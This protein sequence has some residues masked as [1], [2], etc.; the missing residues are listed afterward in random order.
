VDTDLS[1]FI[2][3][4]QPGQNLLAIHGLNV[5]QGSS[6]FL[7]DAEI[8]VS[9]RHIIS[10]DPI[11]AVYTQPIPV[12]DLTTLKARAFSGSEWSALVEA[13]FTVGQPR[14][15]ITELNYHPSDPT[16]DEVST[17]F[18][19][20]NDFEFVELMNAGPS[21]LDLTGIH[22]TDGITFDFSEASIA[23][24]P[25][26]QRVLIVSNAIA[27]DVRYGMG[28]PVIGQ[29]SGKLSN[30]GEAL[31]VTAVDG[32]ILSTVTYGIS[33]P[34]PGQADGLGSSLELTDSLGQV[35]APSNWQASVQFG[36]TPGH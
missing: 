6:D 34:W 7:I 10:E 21:T 12:S 19:S 32:S 9:E 27:F 22:F 30:Q 36:G 14:L 28:L 8:E 17:G 31:E 13:T 33:D 5:S 23:Q 11:A 4:L 3:L 26:G 15:V 24:L 18:A 35:N 1:P 25:P 2:P 29:Y 16:M 20:A